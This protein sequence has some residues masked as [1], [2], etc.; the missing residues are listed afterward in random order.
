MNTSTARCWSSDT[1]NPCP[2]VMDNVP[3]SRGYTGGFGSVLMEKDLGLA[4]GA[5]KEVKARLPLGAAAHQIYGLM[6]E[7]GYSEKDFSSVY[8]FLYQNK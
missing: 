5:A 4:L 7:H 1:Y 3:A 6:C 2:G 8:D